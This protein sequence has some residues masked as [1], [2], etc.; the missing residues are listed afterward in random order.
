MPFILNLETREI[1]KI[2]ESPKGYWE[3]VSLDCKS[4][5]NCHHD[6]EWVYRPAFGLIDKEHKNMIFQDRDMAFDVEYYLR[7]GEPVCYP[8]GP[9]QLNWTN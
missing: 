5:V 9:S 3:S 1:S 6:I 4:L 7:G 8:N 2:S